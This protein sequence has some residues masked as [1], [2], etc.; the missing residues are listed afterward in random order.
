MY[1]RL[2]LEKRLYCGF[3]S[4]FDNSLYS[5]GINFPK[6][7]IGGLVGSMT[8]MGINSLMTPTGWVKAGIT[9]A[10]TIGVGYMNYRSGKNQ[11]RLNKKKKE[12]ELQRAAIEQLNGLRRELFDAGVKI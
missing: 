2:Y 5:I 10:T 12:W 1:N 4:N 3:V 6:F 7:N 9:V 8:S 11:A